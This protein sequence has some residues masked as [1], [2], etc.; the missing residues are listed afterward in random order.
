MTHKIG[1]NKD[2]VNAIKVQT[3]KWDN[4]SNPFFHWMPSFIAAAGLLIFWE[5]NVLL[6]TA[7]ALVAAMCSRNSKNNLNKIISFVIAGVLTVLCFYLIVV[8]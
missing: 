4:H 3:E 8:S 5:L 2:L 7:S 6:G 1:I